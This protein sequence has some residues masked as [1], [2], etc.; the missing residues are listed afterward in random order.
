MIPFDPNN[1][2][3]S[4]NANTTPLITTMNTSNN[5]ANVET[6]QY[7][8]IACINCRKA[9]RKCD[10]SYPVCSE[11]NCRGLADKCVYHKPKKRGPKNSNKASSGSANN[12]ASSS[13]QQQEQE[14]NNVNTIIT[15]NANVT[16]T[17]IPQTIMSTNTLPK[18]IE[19][20]NNSKPTITTLSPN[21]QTNTTNQ[22]WNW[23]FHH[24]PTN[25]TATNNINPTLPSPL[26]IKHQTYTSSHNNMVGSTVAPLNVSNT[27]S[28]LNNKSANRLSPILNNNGIPTTHIGKHTNLSSYRYHPYPPVNNKPMNVTSTIPGGGLPSYTSS[29]YSTTVPPPSVP[30]S[31]AFQTTATEL[32][33]ATIDS[34]IQSMSTSIKYLQSI[35]SIDEFDIDTYY[36]H[37]L[38]VYYD[39]VVLGYP[40]FNRAILSNVVERRLLR[41]VRNSPQMTQ[42]ND[43]YL[44]CLFYCICV[45]VFQRLGKK[46]IARHLF[47]T[48]R[49]LISNLFFYEEDDNEENKNRCGLTFELAVSMALASMYLLG[50]GDMKKASTYYNCGMNFIQNMNSNITNQIDLMS[51]DSLIAQYGFCELLLFSDV[52]DQIK[53]FAIL[54]NKSCHGNLSFVHNLQFHNLESCLS[55]IRTLKEQR[56]SLMKPT[57]FQKPNC[58]DALILQSRFEIINAHFSIL[59]AALELKVYFLYMSDEHEV[60]MREIADII[61]NMTKK[62]EFEHLSPMSLEAVILATKVHLVYLNS[63][64]YSTQIENLQQDLFA[65]KSLDSRFNAL[66]KLHP[67]LIETVENTLQKISTPVIPPILDQQQQQQQL[68]NTLENNIA[69]VPIPQQQNYIVGSMNG[70]VGNTNNG[71][72]Y[73]VHPSSNIHNNYYPPQL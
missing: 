63:Y 65:L 55:A 11:C 60:E 10:R 54:T 41:N 58:Y 15:S 9:H 6:K 4:T 17:N 3:L 64:K 44:I 5:N 23:S 62:P 32:D 70:G 35:S 34:Y 57:N 47:G 7:S 42:D 73:S 1:N 8:S 33:Q 69:P 38:F 28:M 27:A 16:K 61:C 14:Q 66:Q 67:G 31:K 46:D 59:L 52:K 50:N 21:N 22:S 45:T 48:C 51:R 12:N 36:S 18:L 29:N 19:G 2:S 68:N 30:I 49:T 72:L 37:V 25:A 56:S 71:S 20:N 53:C 13:N 24:P 39:R 43:D 40:L 26:P